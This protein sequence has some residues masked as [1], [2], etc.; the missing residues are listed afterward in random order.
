MARQTVTTTELE[1]T[2]EALRQ[3]YQF[4]VDELDPDPAPIGAYLT[5]HNVAAAARRALGAAD[6]PAIPRDN[7]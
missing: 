3:L 4:V 6:R 1:L 5:G 7:F 2:R